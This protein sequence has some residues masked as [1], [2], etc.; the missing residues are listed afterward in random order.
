M[1]AEDDPLDL[2]KPRG[3]QDWQL[4]PH[5]IWYPRTSGIWQTVWF[6]KVGRTYIDKLRWTPK[7]EGY[8]IGFYTRIGGDPLDNLLVEVSLRLG[9]RLLACDRYQVMDGEVDRS[10]ALSDPG[11]DDFRN[12]LL[13]SPDR[14]TL[15]EAKTYRTVGHHEGDPVIGTY[16]T[17]EEVDAWIKRDPIDMFR[18][19]LVEDY[20]LAT[21]DDLAGNGGLPTPRYAYTGLS[22]SNTGGSLYVGL[23]DLALDTIT[24]YPKPAVGKATQLGDEAV[25]ITAAPL[26]TACNDDFAKWCA[27]TTVYGL[28][29]FGT[30]QAQNVAC[31]GGNMDPMCLDTATQMTRP[32]VAPK[33]GDLVINE[34]LSDPTIVTDANGEW[35]EL[36]VLADVDLNDLKIIN[37]PNVDMA[38]LAAAKP[39]LVSPDC[40]RATA[41]SFVLFA[42]NADPM[43]NGN[44]PPVDHVV[45]TS[46]GNASGGLSIP[47]IGA[48][49]FGY[50]LARGLG[51]LLAG[52]ALGLA[53][54]QGITLVVWLILGVNGVALVVLAGVLAQL[55]T[56]ES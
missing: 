28:G 20:G 49:D 19:R 31:G 10:I 43:I 38:T 3:K 24:S 42:H 50:R 15:I 9:D 18:K 56:V 23:G 27:A 54:E 25:C 53:Y 41:G 45:S 30:P 29:D 40:L 6:E 39:L 11:I 55:S 21:P 14:P 4:E 1:R 48:T 17:Q 8:S 46:L 22:L 34:F 47:T 32:I 33:P 7:V 44:L 52:V 36:A 37:K 12:E 5:A 13:W 51:L 16:R 35:F 2:T 26:D